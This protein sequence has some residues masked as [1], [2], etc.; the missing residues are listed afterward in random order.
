MVSFLQKMLNQKKDLLEAH[1]Y[2]PGSLS[3]GAAP[4]YDERGFSLTM[5][6]TVEGKLTL[7]LRAEKLEGL[8]FTRCAEAFSATVKEHNE[9]LNPSGVAYHSRKRNATETAEGGRGQKLLKLNPADVALKDLPQPVVSLQIENLSDV[10]IH[11]DNKHQV[12]VLGSK[13]LTI[14]RSCALMLAYSD[15]S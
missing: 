8:S 4:T 11:I 5:P 1:G 12:W 14:S 9:R 15:R 2:T 6:T 3:E 10:C 13:D 7:P